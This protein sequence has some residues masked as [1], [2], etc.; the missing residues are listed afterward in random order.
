[1][2]QPQSSIFNETSTNYHHLEY[3][4]K[5]G[6]YLPEIHTTLKSALKKQTADVNIVIAFGTSACNTLLPELQLKPFHDF[7][8]LRSPHGKVAA[9]TQADVMF[10]IHSNGISTVLEQAVHIQNAISTIADNKLDI[11]GFQYREN[12]DLIGFVDGTANPKEDARQL[13]ALIPAGQPGEGGS[14]VLSQKWVHD[15]SRFN[16]MKVPEQEAVVG[17]TKED[18]IEL[19][20]DAM[21]ANSHVARTDIA[22]MK[23][24]RRSSPF[25]NASEHGLY[26]LSFACEQQ[27]FTTQL[28]RMYGITDGV[29]DRLID[30]SDAVTGSYWFA[31]SQTELDKLLN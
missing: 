18:D 7:T 10:W 22:G 29:T 6:V 13:A 30:F 3:I 16:A 19:T 11:S 1:M 25:G 14:Y 24:Y 17:R 12:R 21:P 26:F 28:Q 27:R 23:I 15:L 31:P 8:T 5:E 9:A 2:S 4:F 20:G